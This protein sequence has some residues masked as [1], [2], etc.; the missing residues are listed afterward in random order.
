MRD[1]LRRL[2]AAG[3][4]RLPPS[5]KLG[6]N[7][8]IDHSPQ[9]VSQIDTTPI[10]E[11]NWTDLAVRRANEREQ[12]FA[13]LDRI[14]QMVQ[15]GGSSGQLGNW[16]GSA[17]VTVLRWRRNFGR[18]RTQYRGLLAA[19]PGAHRPLPIRPEVG[20]PSV[21]ARGRVVVIDI[22]RLPENGQRLVFAKVVRDI[23]NCMEDVQQRQALGLDGVIIFVDELNKFAPSG[24][25]SPLKSQLIDITARGR[26]SNV[27][28]IGAEQFASEVDKQ[29]FDN[30]ATRVFGRTG[31]S[32]IAGQVYRRL[33]SEMR[34]K[35]TTG[36]LIPVVEG[37]NPI[38]VRTR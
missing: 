7:P 2:D 9:L 15:T 20:Q 37:T 12:V 31:S 30:S 1:I 24:P 25:G 28:L 13:E 29:I 17:G 23:Q 4:I 10:T 3:F 18:L 32:E 36:Y 19:N 27:A 5:Q 14:S 11:I 26:S 6:Q 38:S 35:L 33:S 8:R 16:Q 21:L 34:V 22:Q